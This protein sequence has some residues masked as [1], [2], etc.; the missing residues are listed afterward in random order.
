MVHVYMS[1][2]GIFSRRRRVWCVSLALIASSF[3]GSLFDLALP[4]GQECYCGTRFKLIHG[5]PLGP[6]F[7]AIVSQETPL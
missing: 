6:E 4:A 2:Q 7:H 3:Q 1:I 5:K